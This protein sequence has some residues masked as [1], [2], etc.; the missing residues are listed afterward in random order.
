MRFANSFHYVCTQVIYLMMFFYIERGYCHVWSPMLVWNSNIQM[1]LGCF[2]IDMEVKKALR[3]EK[4]IQR[5]SDGEVT[6]YRFV[7]GNE[8]HRGNDKRDH[9]TKCPRAETRTN[10]QVRMSVAMDK[11]KGNYKVSELVLEHNHPLHLH[12]T[13]H[14]MAS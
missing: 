9:L 8:G 10:C 13:L 2:G 11:K 14:L 1:R 7:C 3:L 12:E 4:G 6:S 5:K